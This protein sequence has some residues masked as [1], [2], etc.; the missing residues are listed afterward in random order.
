MILRIGEV[1][2]QP[3]VY[4]AHWFFTGECMVSNV[5]PVTESEKRL[6]KKCRELNGEVQKNAKKVSTSVKMN[7]DDAKVIASL[8]AEIERAWRMVDASQAEE[9]KAK[10]DI[11]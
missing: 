6:I 1:T 2:R 7:E 11:Q 3:R 8:K 5:M 4:Q 9:A 10:A